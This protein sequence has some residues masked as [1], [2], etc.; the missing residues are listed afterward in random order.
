[1]STRV[2]FAIGE[3]KRLRIMIAIRK[4]LAKKNFSLPK[5]DIHIAKSKPSRTLSFTKDSMGFPPRRITSP[6]N[7]GA[8]KSIPP[9]K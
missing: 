6:L 5:I 1:M 4:Y 2:I 9:T 7:I 8:K 3:K